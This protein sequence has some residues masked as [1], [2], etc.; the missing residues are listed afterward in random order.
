MQPIAKYVS[1]PR[2]GHRADAMGGKWLLAAMCAKVCS[3]DTA[4]TYAIH[5]N[6]RSSP[7]S[8]SHDILR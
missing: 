7:D 3:A 5:A 1:S 4:A 2:D 6:V 8:D